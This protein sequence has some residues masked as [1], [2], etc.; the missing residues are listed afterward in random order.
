MNK[1][2]DEILNI[3]STNYGKVSREDMYRLKH[4]I[5]EDLKTVQSITTPDE[6]IEIID[7]YIN[8]KTLGFDYIG[9]N[10]FNSLVSRLTI[11]RFDLSEEFNLYI[12]SLLTLP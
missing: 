5:E 7:S 12:S 2:I 10:E 4:Q 11:N 3:I 1:H 6:A 8:Y 9:N